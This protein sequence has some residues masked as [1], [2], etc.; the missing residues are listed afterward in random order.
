MFP[1]VVCAECQV[2]ARNLFITIAKSLYGFNFEIL[3][4]FKLK[5]RANNRIGNLTLKVGQI[6]FSCRIWSP[7]RGKLQCG[8]KITLILS[9]VSGKK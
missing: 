2:A 9:D 7:F 3:G 1:N 4:Y 8:A 6:S 5:C